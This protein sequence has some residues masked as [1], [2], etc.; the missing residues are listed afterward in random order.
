MKEQDPNHKYLQAFGPITH[1]DTHLTKQPLMLRKGTVESQV[2]LRS[3]PTLP[4]ASYETLE[5]SLSAAVSWSIKRGSGEG[6]SD[7]IEWA[8]NGSYHY[9]Q[10]QV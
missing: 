1:T 6:E 3:D 4:P 9:V 8:L 2:S 5:K 7:L 10:E